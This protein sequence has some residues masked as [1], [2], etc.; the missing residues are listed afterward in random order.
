MKSPALVWGILQ[1]ARGINTLGSSQ[2]PGKDRRR[3][4]FSLRGKGKQGV[5][6]EYGIRREGTGSR[7]ELGALA[8]KWDAEGIGITEPGW[9]KGMFSSREARI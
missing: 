3:R 5:R 9:G 1:V 6:A 7:W 4:S 2:L 8:R